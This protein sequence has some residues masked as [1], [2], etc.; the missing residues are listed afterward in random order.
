[1]ESTC[2]WYE[3]DSTLDKDEDKRRRAIALIEECKQIEERQSAWYELNLWNA[4]VYNNR[5]L[6]GFRFGADEN[7]TQ[8]LWPANLRTE[9]IVAN[10][11]QSMLSKASSNPLKPTLVPH[12]NSWK[13]ARAVRKADRFLFGAWRQTKAE[14][15]CVQM[16]NDA[17]TASIG[18]VQVCFDKE[19]LHVESVFFDNIVIDNRECANRATPRTYRIRKMVQR[20]AVECLY[21]ISLTQQPDDYL[22][23][24]KRMQ[25][26][27]WVPLVEVWR[28][29]DRN[30]KGGWH[31][32]AC[33]DKMITDDPWKEDY[34]PLVFFPWQDRQ[35][36]FFGKSGVEEV[37]PF[38]VIQ[39]ELNDDIK[40]A[41]SLACRFKVL[42]HANSNIDMGQWDNKNGK[43]MLYSGIAPIPWEAK[44]N[45]M[46]LYNERERN[47]AAAYSHM[48]LSE[49]FANADLPAQVRLDSSA[50]VRE[51]RNMEDARHLR[52]WT[53]FE[54]ARLA[55]ART[56]LLVLAHSEGA[57]NYSTSATGGGNR[58]SAKKIPYKSIKD[59]TEELYTW[60]L[61]PV[62]MSMMSPAS[63][64]ELLRDNTSRGQSSEGME[65]AKRMISNP[66]L[67]M[68]ED[69]E[70]ANR[71]DIER[72]LDLMEEGDYEEPTEFTALSM[73]LMMV[74][75]NMKR[76]MNYDD[77]KVG[78]TM[79]QNHIKWL[80]KA[81][82][83][84]VNA[85][86]M[87]DQMQQAQQMTPFAPTQGVSGTS[88]AQ[89][90]NQ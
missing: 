23:N 42:A 21:G 77:V 45:L 84:T 79:I 57:E 48:G 2:C 71:E 86:M 60:T 78:D 36:G 44:T 20:S 27:D 50:A 41:Q 90:P 56:M 69:L 53:N 32:V 55:V 18:C 88:S 75:A 5:V 25:G 87:Q 81:A 66:D 63:R 62:P 22:Y 49:Q 24:G 46:E 38:Q 34:V 7:M 39:N 1:M 74:N 28:M 40:E 59:L 43:I 19:K 8:E 6:A 76:L 68:I 37:I 33:L 85:Q 14:D 83:I 70:L 82:S 89:A 11:G 72:H 12:G 64:R 58:A 35:S 16:F 61:E 51:Q 9:N 30:G 4:T 52:L 13:T 47:K 29:P 54:Q 17:Y 67:E 80:T 26:R 3:P 10:I 15:A 31:S 73:G 65:D